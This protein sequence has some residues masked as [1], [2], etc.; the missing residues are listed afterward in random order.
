MRGFGVSRVFPVAVTSS[1][2]RGGP[3]AASNLAAL[4]LAVMASLLLAP[5]F[6]GFVA[7]HYGLA[8]AFLMMLP[9]IALTGL[10]AGEAS[11]RRP[12]ASP[13]ST[14]EGSG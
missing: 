11:P 1:A 14:A 12:A 6:I 2:A 7:D 9:L 8:A 13:L 5:P 4:S 3:R 10:L